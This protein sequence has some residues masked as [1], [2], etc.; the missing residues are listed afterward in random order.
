MPE[1]DGS[2]PGADDSAE[3]KSGKD[4]NAGGKK[5]GSKTTDDDESDDDEDEPGKAAGDKS[6]AGQVVFASQADVDKMIQKRVERATKK[7]ADDAKLSETE[8]LEKERDDAL[9][10]VRERDL[11]DDFINASGLDS[12]KATRLFKMYRDDF[13][14]DDKS[15]KVTNMKDVLKTAKSDWPELFKVV[16]GKGD[17]GGGSGDGSGKAVDGDMNSALRKMAGR[18]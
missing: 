3:T 9:A 5:A 13:D 11:K 10:L 8:R 2:Q 4:A 1:N 12:A 7:L 17:G 16:T 15:G 14:V 18:G 6:K